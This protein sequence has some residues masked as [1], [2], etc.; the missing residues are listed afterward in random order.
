L[1]PSI[2][3]GLVGA[4]HWAETAHAPM[5]LD[6]AATT[7]SGIWSPTVET[8]D[9]LARKLGV[10]PYRSFEDLV[11]SV[12]AV[13]F[14]IAPVAQAQLAVE[15]AI[16]G[17]PV[18]LEKPLADSLTNA[19]RIADAVRSA[20]V[21]SLV[22]LTNRYHPRTRQF[23]KEVKDLE[24]HGAL[25]AITA[26][27]V[28]SRRARPA[29]S[30]WRG[31]MGVLFDFGPHLFDLVELVGG[32]VIELRATSRIEGVVEVTMEH[33]SGCCSQLLISDRVGVQGALVDVDVYGTEGHRAF[34]TRNLDYSVVWPEVR[35]EFV[36]AVLLQRAPT[37][38]VFRGVEVQSLIEAAM[39]SLTSAL[40][41][42]SAPP[43][44]RH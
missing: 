8:S 42:R 15:A 11:A 33:V 43:A 23:V 10:T 35:R 19:K 2:R 16:A 3:I 9:A 14:A 18:I 32:P 34:T 1:V 7:L 41:I 27:Y 13:D 4:A 36:E 37:V 44:T 6:G 21:A 28:G 20:D 12:D 17:R 5:H 24:S 30:A 38:D 39:R 29:T 25:L 31:D 40:P 22:F 26:R